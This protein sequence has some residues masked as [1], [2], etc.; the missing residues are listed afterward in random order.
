[1]A[2]TETIKHK[3]KSLYQAHE[4]SG[5]ITNV[6]NYVAEQNYRAFIELKF[7]SHVYSMSIW[8]R[9]PMGAH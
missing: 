3:F 4:V 2:V 1:M 5:T 6:E 8:W 7:L 9:H